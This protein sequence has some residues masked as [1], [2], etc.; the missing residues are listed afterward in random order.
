MDAKP[1]RRWYQFG[2]WIWFA[3]VIYLAMAAR[4]IG[5]I[6]EVA[7]ECQPP[8]IRESVVLDRGLTSA[9][10]SLPTEA[11]ADPPSYDGLSDDIMNLRRQKFLEALQLAEN[12]IS[13]L[14]CPP[15]EGDGMDV[16]GHLSEAAI[17]LL[18]E[19]VKPGMS[20]EEVSVHFGFQPDSFSGL[21]LEGERQWTFHAMDRGGIHGNLVSFVGKFKSGKLIEGSLWI[22][23]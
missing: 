12:N 2:L 10:E 4:G 14:L 16:P 18:A 20:V 17:D 22:P 19:S 15:S 9:E 21:D 23:L 5:V 1:Q 3:G 11:P 6:V 8:T 13:G 7:N